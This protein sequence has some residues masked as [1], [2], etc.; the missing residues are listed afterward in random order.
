M[1]STSSVIYLL[2]FLE[3]SFRDFIKEVLGV[4][5]QMYFDWFLFVQKH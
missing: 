4:A 1:A 2:L 3:N 5:E